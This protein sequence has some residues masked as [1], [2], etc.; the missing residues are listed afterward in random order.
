MPTKGKSIKIEC[1]PAATLKYAI[2][3]P[4]STATATRFGNKNAAI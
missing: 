4:I 3:R 1:R 2:I